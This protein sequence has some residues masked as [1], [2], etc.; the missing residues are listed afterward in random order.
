MAHLSNV[1]CKYLLTASPAE[2]SKPGERSRLS[3]HGVV[4]P[5]PYQRRGSAQLGAGSSVLYCGMNASNWRAGRGAGV[6]HHSGRLKAWD[7]AVPSHPSDLLLCHQ[8]VL[9]RVRKNNYFT[10]VSKYCSITLIKPS[11]KSCKCVALN[12]EILKRILKSHSKSLWI[13]KFRM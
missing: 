13:W 1:P 2:P 8:F 9:I 3:K 11:E 4:C 10:R 5:C 7:G 6:R 12:C